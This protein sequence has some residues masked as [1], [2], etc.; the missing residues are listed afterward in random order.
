MNESAGLLPSF[1][2]VV[3]QYFTRSVANKK[4]DLGEDSSSSSSDENPIHILKKAEEPQPGC[5]TDNT[6]STRVIK[7]PVKMAPFSLGP[8]FSDLKCFINPFDGSP[9]KYKT[10]IAECERAL[11]RAKGYKDVEDLLLDYI[12]TQVSA[13]GCKFVNSHELTSWSK[14]KEI[15]DSKFSVKLTEGKILHKMTDIKQGKLNVFD[16][17]GEFAELIKDYAKVLADEMDIKDPLYIL[18]MDR[19]NKV[20]AQAFESGLR[21]DIRKSLIFQEHN[22]LKEVYDLAKKFEDKEINRPKSESNIVDQ[23]KDILKVADEAGTSKFKNPQVNHMQR[24]NCQICDGNHTA[25]DCPRNI[26][27]IVCQLCGTK[28]HSAPSCRRGGNVMRGGYNGNRGRSNNNSR[29][30]YFNRNGYQNNNSSNNNNY[31]GNNQGYSRGRG[32]YNN[33]NSNNHYYR[34]PN[35]NNNQDQ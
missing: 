19:I 33:G 26:Q 9:G 18:S 13:L 2:E 8:R 34:N 12:M 27:N 30:G 4:R 31:S 23:L 24:F 1:T 5:S 3:S 35:N 29:G 15:C 28:G 21:E 16:Y 20:A 32:G 6:Q 17:Y 11:A 22:S 7:K 10:F 14:V 25:I